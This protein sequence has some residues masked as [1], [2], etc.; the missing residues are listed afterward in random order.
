M[1]TVI[2]SATLAACGSAPVVQPQSEY[3]V[4]TIST[5]DKEL[6]TIYSAAIRGRQD[7]AIYPQVSGTLTKLCVE[8]GQ[9]VRRE[10]C[11][12]DRF[13][14]SNRPFNRVCS[15]YNRYPRRKNLVSLGI[16]LFC[17]ERCV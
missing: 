15:V 10:M 3:K 1:M 8:E 16:I 6:Q 4:M 9:T 11:I 17:P 12:R 5:T 2:C 13:G 7:I 14:I